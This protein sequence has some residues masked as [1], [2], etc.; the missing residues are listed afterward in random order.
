MPRVQGVREAYGAALAA[1]QAGLA[2]IC[3][4]AGFGLAVHHTDHTPETALMAL[5]TALDAGGAR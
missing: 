4:A 2:A 1:Q 5:W 3:A